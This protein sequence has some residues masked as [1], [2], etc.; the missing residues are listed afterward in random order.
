MNM[1]YINSWLKEH[2]DDE[3]YE[4]TIG[5]AQMAQELALKYGLDADKAYLAGLLHDCAKCETNDKLLEIINKEMK[6]VVECETKNYKTLHAPV[7]AYYAKTLFNVNDEE[8]L[9]AIRWHTLGRV[10]MSVFDMI[11]FL[12]DKIERK[13]RDKKDSDMILNILEKYKGE[14]GL[15]LALLK[16][17]ER[18]IK[19][20]VDRQLEICSV[21]IGVYNELI[22]Y[23]NSMF[24]V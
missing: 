12:S 20:L 2:L 18:T 3:R 8:I 17:F 13:T 1:D 23:K 16:C 6:D 21:T 14:S 19:S 7:S 24:N 15:K 5:V 9:C 11:I 4:H 22:S 10:D